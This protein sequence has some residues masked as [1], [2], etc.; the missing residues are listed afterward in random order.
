[1][2]DFV[3]EGDRSAFAVWF[4]DNSVRIGFEDENHRAEFAELYR[5]DVTV[6]EDKLFGLPHSMDAR[7]C[8]ISLR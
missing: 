6:D 8:S 4:F 5:L 1:M 7:R 2:A 3:T